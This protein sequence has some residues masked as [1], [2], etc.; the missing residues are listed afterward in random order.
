MDLNDAQLPL[1]FKVLLSEV[2]EGV[3]ALAIRKLS[4]SQDH[5]TM[6]WVE[7]LCA[8]P[9]GKYRELPSASPEFLRQMRERLDK[10]VY[11]HKEAKGHIVRLIARWVAN[12]SAG[13][14]VIGIHGDMGTG[15]TSLCK[16]VCRVLGLPFAFIPLGGANDGC[17][18][19]GHSATYEGSTWGRVADSLMKAGCMNPVLFFDELDKISETTRG[20]EVTN[21]LVHLTDASQNDRFHD[22]FFGG[23][24][25]D[26]SR[27]LMVFSYNDENKV[28][29]ILRDRMTCI[30]TD[31]YDTKDKIALTRAHVLPSVCEEFAM[32]ADEIELDDDVLRHIIATVQEER[33]VRNLRRALVDVVGCINL[34][35]VESGQLTDAPKTKVSVNDVDR[36]VTTS[37]R[38]DARFRGRQPPAFMY[39]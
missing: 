23:V 32:R 6:H 15:K 35:R 12:P 24:S 8:L 33:G 13:G 5:K 34:K 14:L 25:L 2:D 1:R 31:G 30:H 37:R 21:I 22:K 3:K 29:P 36:F 38:D 18:L 20:K 4:R 26:L 10:E 9:V 16:A 11:G 39:C 7:S 28:D 27:S 17:Y 19:D